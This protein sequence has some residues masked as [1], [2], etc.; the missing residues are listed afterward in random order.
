MTQEE[1]DQ[2]ELKQF[3]LTH[4]QKRTTVHWAM[5]VAFFAC[6]GFLTEQHL[7]HPEFNAKLLMVPIILC[8]GIFIYL[9]WE[10][11]S[12]ISE[13][14]RC[15]KLNHSHLSLFSFRQESLKI[16]GTISIG[17]ISFAFILPLPDTNSNWILLVPAML[18]IILPYCMGK[19]QSIVLTKINRQ[20]NLLAST[21]YTSNKPHKKYYNVIVQDDNDGIL[22]NYIVIIDEEDSMSQPHIRIEKSPS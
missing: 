21:P 22:K 12:T 3:I 5:V 2:V 14:L 13:L 20:I 7:N 8:A 15:E 17:F 6:I 1:R 19:L 18:V 10:E 9:W 11:A 16:C 4:W